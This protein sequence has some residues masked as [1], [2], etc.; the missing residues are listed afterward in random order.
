ML[1]AAAVG[2]ALGVGMVA[3][4]WA[5]ARRPGPAR[6]IFPLLAVALALAG[7]AWNAKTL[8][9]NFA[10]PKA[11]DF[12]AYYMDGKLAVARQ[13]FYDPANYRALAP[14]L[15]LPYE[16]D[17]E[18]REV[19][20]GVGFHY[21]PPTILLHYPLG[22]FEYETAHAL[23][24]VFSVVVLVADG[25]LLYLMFL[26]G[27]GW[28][29]MAAAG[30]LFLLFP[31]VR[32]TL[33]FEQTSLMLLLPCL[34]FRR[35]GGRD[36]AGVWAALA[37]SV[38]PLGAFLWLYLVLRRQWRA[39]G[40]AALTFA[41]LCGV[42][43]VLCGPATVV[44]FFSPERYTHVPDWQYSEYVNQS[45]LAEVIRLTGPSPWGG[46]ATH[47]LFLVLGGLLF[48]VGAWAMARL[49]AGRESLAQSLLLPLALLLYPGTLNHYSV[50]L[51]PVVFRLATGAGAA[52]G[53]WV[54]VGATYALMPPGLN[55]WAH[56]AL[57]GACAWQ[58]RRL[59]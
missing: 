56:L 45:L 26:R 58:A 3:L 41:L 23:W 47:P 4:L 34:L 28:E 9:D 30:A 10:H 29:G 11:W 13:N 42:V 44:S 25:A 55:V 33:Y 15:Q 27:R 50:L 48:A 8:Y 40:A 19:K 17:Q 43:A 39:L 12:L 46:P 18:F 38:K 22:F 59:E 6:R 57:F 36:R 54:L 2:I 32:Y 35:D 52:W 53:S 5:G 37:V 31:A 21:A 1:R 20:L 16:I 14:Q 7:L 51:L 24:V 49:P